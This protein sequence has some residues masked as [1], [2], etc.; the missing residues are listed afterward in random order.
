MRLS[1]A[2]DGSCPSKYLNGDIPI[3][4]CIIIRY[5]YTAYIASDQD[6]PSATKAFARFDNIG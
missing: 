2:K 6:V 1:Q 3:V 5:V 4:E